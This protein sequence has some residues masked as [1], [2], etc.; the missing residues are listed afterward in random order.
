HKDVRKNNDLNNIPSTKTTTSNTVNYSKTSI[1]S[2]TNSSSEISKS[3]TTSNIDNINKS[4][5]TYDYIMN[6]YPKRVEVGEEEEKTRKL[7]YD[8]KD[9]KNKEYYAN[10]IK[11]YM[12]KNNISKENLTIVP[13]PASS[14]SK[15]HKR[16]YE[17]FKELSDSLNIENGFDY[18]KVTSDRDAKHLSEDRDNSNKNYEIDYNKIKNKNILLLDDIITT[19]NGFSELS[20]EL[21]KN[22]SKEVKGL[23][24]AKT[25][26]TSTKNTST[27]TKKVE[28]TTSSSTKNSYSPKSTYN[29]SKETSTKTTKTKSYQPYGVKRGED[30]N[31]YNGRG[32]KIMYPDK[33]F[34]AIRKNREKNKK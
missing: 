7:V 19:G 24:L 28:T 8:F 33:Y 5:P 34:E 9:G 4:E 22:G 13:I 10:L 31:Y 29:N 15:N 30:G 27:T 25:V 17:L 26:K 21:I 1:H 18:I 11:D 2:Y 6:Y 20:N 14:S 12:Q 23:F 3:Q 32:E 16:Y